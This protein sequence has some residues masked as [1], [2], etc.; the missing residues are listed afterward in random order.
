MQEES[1]K[2]VALEKRRTG[3]IKLGGYRA[4][5]TFTQNRFQVT[6]NNRPAFEAAVAF[7]KNFDNLYFRGPTGCGKSHLAAIAARK[8]LNNR[9]IETTNQMG[10]SRVIRSSESADDESRMIHA[11]AALGVL[12]IND[13]GVAKDT[14]FM[15]SVI[16]EVLDLRYMN[17]PGGLIVTSNLS[18]SELSRKLGDDRISSRLAGMCKVFNLVGEPDKRID[19]K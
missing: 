9:D 17:R 10:I 3:A 12:V 16:Y 7:N 8:Y 4:L 1:D 6:E 11:L 13:L 18:L 2:R 14:E 19:G 15:I 5:D